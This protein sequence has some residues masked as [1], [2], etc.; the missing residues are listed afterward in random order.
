MVRDQ[1]VTIN[2]DGETSR[3]FCFVANAVQANVRAALAPDDVQGEVF[4]IAVG[5]RTSLSTLLELI[6][7]TLAIHQV[8]YDREPHF[9]DFSP[10]DV[11]HSE[12]D[13]SKAMRLI[14]F[15]PSH[16][17]GEGLAAAVPWYLERFRKDAV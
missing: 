11:R 5:E 12:A 1:Q 3:D 8:R 2:G 7:D 10:G 6:R 4:N 16:D 13:I 17:V 14:G 9:V 15:A